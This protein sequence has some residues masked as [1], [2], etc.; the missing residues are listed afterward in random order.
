LVWNQ[1]LSAI[2]SGDNNGNLK[3]HLAG[4]SSLNS[5]FTVSNSPIYAIDWSNDRSYI[6]VG[7]YDENIAQYQVKFISG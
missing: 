7:N 4:S 5:S 6:A 2:V 3:L 1:N